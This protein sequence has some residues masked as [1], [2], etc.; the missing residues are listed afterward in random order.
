M[1]QIAL[2]MSYTSIAIYVFIFRIPYADSSTT[3]TEAQRVNCTVQPSTVRLD[4]VAFIAF[5]IAMVMYVG[6][7]VYQYYLIFWLSAR[8]RWEAFTFYLRDLENVLQL[9][10]MMGAF[11]I[12]GALLSAREKPEEQDWM[13]W[14]AAV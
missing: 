3:G 1:S 9:A 13:Y 6:L 12:M 2:Y 5:G 11:A 10:F 4:P 7:E 14:I 8:S